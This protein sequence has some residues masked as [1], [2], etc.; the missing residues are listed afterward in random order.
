[1]AEYQY[2]LG[3]SNAH[4]D[5]MYDEEMRR[6][7]ADKMLTV[8][9]D[10][11][12][13]QLSVL[14]ALDVGCSTGII[15]GR[16]AE[17]LGSVVGVDIDEPAIRYAQMEH[18]SDTCRFFVGD[19]MNLQFPAQSFDVVICAQVYEH[20]P[21]AHRLVAEI[22]RV[23]R[24]GGVCY[25]AAAN[26]LQWV[27]AHYHLPLLSVVPKRLSSLVLRALGRGNSYYETHLTLW[28]LRA[29]VAQFDVID[30]TL[31][32]LQDPW[33][34]H[35]TDMIADGSLKQKMALWVVRR[36]YW[37]CPTYIWLLRRVH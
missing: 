10:Y 29:L 16:L 32:I 14:R 24:P 33:R 11:Y 35:A 18:G 26:R 34:F 2:Q 30:Y 25:F 3:F 20:V 13:G 17:R 5:D 1:M 19:S 31:T 23:L 27:E 36:A 37:L 9:D 8:L 21:D 6:Q 22:H 7:K 12:G 28:G 15:A 4:A